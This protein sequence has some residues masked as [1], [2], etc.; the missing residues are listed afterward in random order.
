MID[1]IK[2]YP[3]VFT[4]AD[5]FGTYRE[6]PYIDSLAKI[7]KEFLYTCKDENRH[8]GYC[9]DGIIN[10]YDF[11]SLEIPVV[12]SLSLNFGKDAIKS[13]INVLRQNRYSHETNMI[14]GYENLGRDILVCNA[15]DKLIIP[16]LWTAHI[17]AR[18]RAFI[19]GDKVFGDAIIMLFE[20]MMES[21]YYDID[22][23]MKL[24]PIS[25]SKEALNMLI[26]D[27]TARD[28]KG[29]VIGYEK[30]GIGES[31]DEKVLA[32]VKHKTHHSK[33]LTWKEKKDCFKNAV[34]NVMNQNNVD[35]DYRFGKPTQWKAVYRFAVDSGIMYDKE[36]PN[37]PQDK[38]TPQYAVFEK[39][40]LELQLD[41]DPPTRLP[42]TKSAIND[43]TKGNYVRYNAPYPWSQDGITADHRSILL[44]TE[45]DNVYVALREE[46]DNL[47]SQAEKTL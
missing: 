23:T 18:A 36:D 26:N 33:E 21:S 24:T 9:L 37:E 31:K 1:R 5:G 25:K 15:S 27:I 44:Y 41:V 28:K 43:I 30:D 20:L 17:Y 6:I 40:A 39:L 11:M 32:K 13:Y 29:T 10:L 45:L 34:L 12:K 47:V 3:R 22:F 7:V 4:S 42:F 8:Q 35:G 38:S 2:T 16:L 14:I 46:Y 19:G